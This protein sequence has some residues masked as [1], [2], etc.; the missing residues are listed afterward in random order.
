MLCAMAAISLRD[1]AGFVPFLIR[2]HGIKLLRNRMRN[3]GYQPRQAGIVF[4]K[5]CIKAQLASAAVSHQGTGF[6]DCLEAPLR[7]LPRGLVCA[8]LVKNQERALTVQIGNTRIEN[9]N[10]RVH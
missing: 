2:P 9:S 8:A 6:H 7:A 3:L 4:V 10:Q 1:E 5:E